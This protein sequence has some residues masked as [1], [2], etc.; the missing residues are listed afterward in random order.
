[1]FQIHQKLA[2][3]TNESY[4]IEDDFSLF[5]LVNYI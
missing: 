3:V 2:K 1:M 4:I 5:L